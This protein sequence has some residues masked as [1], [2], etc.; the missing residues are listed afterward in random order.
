MNDASSRVS[1]PP[2]LRILAGLALDY[3]RW[4]Q[5]VP[6]VLAW[7]FLLLMVGAMLLVSFQQPSFE[8][9]DG[10]VRLYERLAGPPE[11]ADGGGPDDDASAPARAADSGAVAFTD[12]DLERL[13]LKVWALMA[14]AG[15]LLGMAWRLLF[16][17]P[18][19]PS[20]KRKLV[21]AGAACAACT[22]LFLL[23]YFFGSEAFDDPF[24]QWMALFVGVPLVVWCISA[25]SLAISTLVDIAKRLIYR[26][27]SRLP[28]A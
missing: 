21:I 14:L 5:L 1:P 16:G 24:A 9:V 20:L 6:M 27:A 15:W 18:P 13:V 11:P 23:A 8:L 10:G 7:A 22:G 17:R 25:Y 4:T 26:G 2:L 28:A 19:R 3:L 12:E